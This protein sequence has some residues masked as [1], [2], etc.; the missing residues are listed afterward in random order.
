M[1]HLPCCE[2]NLFK[3]MYMQWRFEYLGLILPTKTR[4]QIQFLNFWK[5]QDR[6]IRLKLDNRINKNR[7]TKI[8]CC[9]IRSCSIVN[10]YGCKFVGHV[11]MLTFVVAKIFLSCS[12]QNSVIFIQSCILAYK[13]F[14]QKKFGSVIFCW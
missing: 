14:S 11:L 9:N 3:K 10:V 6:Y 1:F 7:M 4:I 8:I 12:N 2:H 13:I 5:I